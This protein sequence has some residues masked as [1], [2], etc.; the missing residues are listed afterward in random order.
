V[1]VETALTLAILADKEVFM[2]RPSPPLRF[3][4]PRECPLNAVRIHLDQ[5]MPK[6][7]ARML[8][9]HGLDVSTTD[10]AGI[11][12]ADDLEQLSY[13]WRQQRLLITCDLGFAGLHRNGA[14]HAGI[15]ICPHS[16][17]HQRVLH[18]VLKLVA[19]A[20]NCVP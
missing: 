5:C 6:R 14:E 8:R 17:D 3:L 4:P 11:A 19:K 18:F 1:A 9:Q 7:L 13:A 10:R 16:R 20:E 12:G 15:L 2:V